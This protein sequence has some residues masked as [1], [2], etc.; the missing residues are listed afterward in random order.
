MYKGKYRVANPEYQLDLEQQKI[1]SP[2]L[3]YIQCPKHLTTKLSVIMKFL[4]TILMVVSVVTSGF[5]QDTAKAE[6]LVEQG[7]KLH[8]VGRY[9]EAIAV[10]KQALEADADHPRALYEMSYTYYISNN[11]DSAILLSNKLLSLKNVSDYILRNVYVTLGSLYDDTGESQKATDIY[12][13]G[14]SKFPGFYLLYFNLG[15]TELKTSD[16]KSAI[17]NFQQA[18]TLKPLHAG[19]NFEVYKLL[20]GNN[21]IP[22]ILAASLVCITEQNTKR[23]TE[24]AAF[25]KSALAPD[26]KSDSAKKNITI[27]IPSSSL[28]EVKEN[29]FSAVELGVSLIA[30]SPEIMD[31]LQLDN[32]AKKISF[33]FQ[34]VCN[35]MT[36]SK[37]N[38]GFYWKFY[39]PFFNSLNQN[40]YMDVLTNTILMNLETTSADWIANNQIRVFQ[41]YDWVKKFEW[42]KK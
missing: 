11:F 4:L 34:S 28:S 39:T 13:Q 12:Q 25:I 29:N 10:Y 40:G 14:I 36:E 37:K 2:K 23:S 22:A 6:Q 1:V 31:T 3:M 7:V 27:Y 26:I 30:A 33:Q 20:S 17:K 24:C 16:E 32:D 35:F 19:S 38:K 18:L 15:I 41:F 8:D 21:K 42:M 5:A 9:T